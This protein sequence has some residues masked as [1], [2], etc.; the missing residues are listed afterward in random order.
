MAFE[1]LV[2]SSGLQLN[3]ANETFWL[4]L[5]WVEAQNEESE[6]GK[7]ALF[8][9]MAKHLRFDCMDPG[10]MV[11]L[12]SKHPRIIAAGMQSTALMACLIH[13]NLARRTP[14]EVDMFCKKGPS[15]LPIF[16]TLGKVDTWTFDLGFNAAEIAAI[17]SGAQCR[18]VVGLVA[19]LPWCLEL[20]RM[21]DDG[22]GARQAAFSTMCSLPFEW[23]TYEDGAGFYYQYKLK[24]GVGAQRERIVTKGNTRYWS[25]VAESTD[26]DVLGTWT[27]VFR[28]GSN[29]LVDGVL[30]VRLTVMI[31]NDQ[32][33]ERAD[34]EEDEE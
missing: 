26:Y 13:A 9:R 21:D 17:E 29:Y 14:E 25:T 15:D 8:T 23:M 20:H 28:E 22:K 34:E 30:L 24:V 32:G 10:Y 7:Q 16:N 4:M 6:E 12:V 33:P 18:K 1:A 19:G 31:N 5:S 3:T 27:E 11:L 2:S